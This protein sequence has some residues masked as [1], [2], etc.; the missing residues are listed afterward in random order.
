MKTAALFLLLLSVIFLSKCSNN[1][2]DPKA[3]ISAELTSSTEANPIS[4]G[5][6]W[7]KRQAPS[8]LSLW[9]RVNETTQEVSYQLPGTAWKKVPVKN[10]SRSQT[11]RVFSD[12][13]HF[14]LTIH[15][16]DGYHPPGVVSGAAWLEEYKDPMSTEGGN[17]FALNCE[18]RF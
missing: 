2:D 16:T 7:A 17:P 18:G 12:G 13:D 8:F 1:K 4:N 6:C 15:T 5:R 10:I 9:V 3:G 14:L 11:V